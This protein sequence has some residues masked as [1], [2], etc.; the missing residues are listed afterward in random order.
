MIVIDLGLFAFV[1]LGIIGLSIFYYLK[2]RLTTNF[3]L[4]SLR[5]HL[6]FDV[7]V[8]LVYDGRFFLLHLVGVCVEGRF[9]IR[10]QL[11]DV[12]FRQR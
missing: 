6:S 4:D 2:Q 11:A 12:G 9:Y 5:F 10:E 8:K 7:F 3:S 1:V